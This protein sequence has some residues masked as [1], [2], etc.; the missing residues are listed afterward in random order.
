MTT[1]REWLYSLDVADLADWFDAEHAEGIIV[2]NYV[3]ETPSNIRKGLGYKDRPPHEKSEECKRFERELDAEL[4]EIDDSREKLEADIWAGCEHL[5]TA[6][7][8]ALVNVHWRN[9]L[10]WLDRQAAITERECIGDAGKASLM[11]VV[12]HERECY[13][14]R[15]AELT[16]ERDELKAFSGRLETA[17]HD[18]LGVT[19]FGVDYVTEEFMLHVRDTL[20]A[21]RDDWK[22]KAEGLTE[23]LEKLG[24][25]V[26]ANGTVFEP[27]PHVDAHSKA[28]SKTEPILSEQSES[29][30]DE[31]DS[32]EKLEEDVRKFANVYYTSN[33]L[34]Y[35]KVIELLDRQAAITRAEESHGWRMAASGPIYEYRQ[36]RDRL[37]AKL[38]EMESERD[39]LARDLAEC[40][41]SRIELKDRCERAEKALVEMERER[42]YWELHT[43]CWADKCKDAEAERDAYHE[44]AVELEI[45]LAQANGILKNTTHNHAAA[46][47]KYERAQADAARARERQLEAERRYAELLEKP[48]EG[49]WAE[50]IA[51]L[52]AG[53]RELREKLSEAIG[54]A[55]EISRLVDLEGVC[56]GR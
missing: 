7:R 40:D 32:R 20:T 52:E 15:I 23:A 16:A 12:A 54:H 43:D 53:N 30:N 22:A 17:A 2:N 8:H 42:D 49:A 11:G 31:S 34:V 18:K 25:S 47:A 44:R 26:L 10:G 36:E 14:K 55:H 19:L 29:L 51:V 13:D 33:L 1:N 37:Q 41:E 28:Q 50:R 6:K 39:N 38:D 9:L 35:D 27:A 56:D 5:T 45:E 3:T 46:K 24:C 4:D 48:P 21:E